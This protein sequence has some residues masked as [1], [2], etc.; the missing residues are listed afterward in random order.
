M[1]TP[2]HQA[3]STLAQDGR[4]GDSRGG[5]AVRRILVAMLLAVVVY[6]GFAVWRGLGKMATAQAIRRTALALLAD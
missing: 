5:V 1:T 2:S 3:S 4:S 6:G